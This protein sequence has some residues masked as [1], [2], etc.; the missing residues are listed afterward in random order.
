MRKKGVLLSLIETMNFIHKKKCTDLEI[1]VL[2]GT[3]YD[4][5][6]I[7]FMSSDGR[8]FDEISLK[9]FSEDTSEGSFP[10]ARWAPENEIDGLFLFGN[11][12]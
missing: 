12:G 7:A 11:F 4:C 10:S 6:N 8:K 5:L 9:F 1:P 3:F 2:F